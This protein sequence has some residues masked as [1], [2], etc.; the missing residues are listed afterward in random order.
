M[1]GYN[2]FL[3]QDFSRNHSRLGLEGEVWTPSLRL[4]TNN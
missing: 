2:T 4:A 1:V 3:D